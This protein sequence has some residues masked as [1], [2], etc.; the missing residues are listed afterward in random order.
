MIRFV[1]IAFIWAGL[2]SP[3]AMA[4][5]TAGV[6]AIRGLVASSAGEP[7]ADVAVCARPF[8][9]CTVTN[10]NGRFLLS[11]LRA[12]V[13]EL[14]VLGPSSARLTTSVDVRAGR[15]TVVEVTLPEADAIRETVTVTAPTF[16][17]AEEIKNSAYL[18]SAEEVAQSAGALQDVSRYVQ[19]LPGVVIGT[20]DFR[21]DLIVRG[22]SPLE[23]L[24]VV[25]NVEIPNINTFANFAS[26]GGTVSVLDALLLQDVTF[27]TGGYP[28]AY[29]NRASSVLQ[30]ALREGN[31]QRTS[32][33]VTF[34]FAG[35]GGVVEGPIAGGRGS[36]IVS[37]RRSVLDLV[38]EDVGI[39]G[40][41]VLHTFNGKATYDVTPRDRLWVLNVTG[42]DRIRLGLNENSDLSDE[43]SNVDIRYSGGRSA[44]GVN[45]QRT[46]G[47]KG[48]GLLGA[49]YSRAW[50]RS[51]VDD[52]LRYAIPDPGTPIEA[53]LAAGETVFREHSAESEMSV[54]Y[55]V[56]AYAGGVGKIQGGVSVRRTAIDYDTA[57]PFGT[58]SPYFRNSDQNPFALREQ[59]AS[60][61]TASYAQLSRSVGSRV[62]IT[63]G[64]R[65]DHFGLLSETR[66]APRAGLSIALAPKLA[67][68][69]SAGQYYQQPLPIFVRSFAANKALEPFR[70]DHAVAGIVWTEDD[71]RFTAEVY[72]KRYRQYPVSTQVPSLS[73]A[74]IGDTFAVRDI[75][76]PL[77]SAGTGEASGVELFAERRA[78]ASGR[79]YGQANLAL[80]RARH[81]GADGALRPGAFDY[82]VVANV[83][84]SAR[85]GER[86]GLS[87]R[88]AFLSGRPYTPIDLEAS[89]VARRAIY[90]T[91]LV[92]SERSTAYFRAD[93]RVDRSFTVNGQPL[94][95]FAGVQNATNRRNVAGY[96]W[97]R[98]NNRLKTQEQLGIF[99]IL[100]LDW[101]F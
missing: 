45:W 43:L 57:S 66:L 87:T 44:T 5:D 32:G 20:D 41:P 83:L 85:L 63:A 11:D 77:V 36:W 15:E 73:L 95:V 58:D 23:N 3:A 70:A 21:N 1:A 40:V 50:V 59:S 72:H 99:P 98:R 93:L 27:L 81:A 60:Y 71:A 51:T 74:N 6:G 52:L 89:A 18:V 4:Q 101:Q 94:R 26:A 96:S 90:D 100:G 19:S 49:T 35:A 79:W 62:N 39:G 64:A 16:V 42:V 55:D 31:R 53:Q 14:E 47:D 17:A 86:W 84:A 9:R 48:V 56:T 65:L 67:L 38:T 7:V 29:G 80:S 34:G 54:K 13:Y 68:R 82:P 78:R 61:L 10:A 24:Y 75:L 91:T 25:D 69:L 76:F 33:R 46:F 12:G 37:A 2:V 8:D 92:N 97:D 22:G 30:V 88:V 28:A